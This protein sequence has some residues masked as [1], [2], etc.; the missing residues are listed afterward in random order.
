MLFASPPSSLHSSAFRPS[1]STL[2]TTWMKRQGWAIHPLLR[3]C[4]LS[5]PHTS[6][7]AVELKCFDNAVPWMF[8]VYSRRFGTRGLC[9][10]V[11]LSYSPP[12]LPSSSRAHARLV[13]P[14]L[15]P[16]PVAAACCTAHPSA[17]EHVALCRC[18]SARCARR[19]R[20]SPAA[21]L[22]HPPARHPYHG[23]TCWCRK[24][25]CRRSKGD[26][27]RKSGRRDGCPR[28][29]LPGSVAKVH[30]GAARGIFRAGGWS[31]HRFARVNSASTFPASGTMKS[32]EESS[33]GRGDAIA[34]PSN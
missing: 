3:T 6:Q 25:S 22:Q 30:C 20:I 28:G 8:H 15:L 12:F 16:A 31:V 4:S 24:S 10:P 18:Q 13:A 27:R 5:Q 33:G 11:R 1:L 2:T 17:T 9:V 14:P 21:T 32:G 29:E 34:A 19:L 23:R 26:E 7:I